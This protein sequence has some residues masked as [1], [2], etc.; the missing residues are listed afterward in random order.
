MLKQ[1]NLAGIKQVGRLGL[2]IVKHAAQRLGACIKLDSAEG[3]GT[4]VQII[5]SP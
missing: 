1:T 2:S 5:F 3:A 4:T